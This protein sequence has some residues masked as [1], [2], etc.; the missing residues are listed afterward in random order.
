M[1]RGKGERK[2]RRT[3]AKR[4]GGERP[5]PGG[6]GGGTW[7]R[8]KLGGLSKLAEAMKVREPQAGLVQK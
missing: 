2:E 1:C 7:T 4:A 8:G 6:G 5:G 3:G